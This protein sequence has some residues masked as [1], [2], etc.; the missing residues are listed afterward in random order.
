[1][2]LLSDNFRCL[3]MVRTVGEATCNKMVSFYSWTCCND[4]ACFA[5]GPRGS[6]IW[7]LR[8]ALY[9]TDAQ[10]LESLTTSDLAA[11]VWTCW[12]SLGTCC[13]RWHQGCTFS[14]TIVTIS[15]CSSLGY[16]EYIE[17]HFRHFLAIG[18]NSLCE[19]QKTY[20]RSMLAMPSDCFSDLIL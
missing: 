9:W 13:V 8:L 20:N 12:S 1:M 6:D 18:Q 16:I 17:V 4:F 2:L 19:I 11:T 10:F 15:S 5:H 7:C 14:K 3:H